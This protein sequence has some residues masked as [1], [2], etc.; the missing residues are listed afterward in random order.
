M[1]KLSLSFYRKPLLALASLFIVAVAS[2]Q[3]SKDKK[4]IADAATAKAEFI[5][6][7]GLMQSLFNNAYGYVIF[8]NVGKGGIGIGGNWYG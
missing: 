6:T 4:V 8:P 2:A 1:K 7:D 3:N 5:K